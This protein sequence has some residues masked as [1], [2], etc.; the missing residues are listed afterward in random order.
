MFGFFPDG[1]TKDSPSW[2]VAI[3]A[4]NGIAFVACLLFLNFDLLTQ[5]FALCTFMWYWMAFMEP[6]EDKF[7]KKFT[8]RGDGVAVAGLIVATAG[9]LGAVLVS[10]VPYPMWA[11]TKARSSAE[12]IARE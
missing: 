4:G 12:G 9:C 6:S 10:M 1:V 2:M 11:M 7:S 3:G 8:I 5:I